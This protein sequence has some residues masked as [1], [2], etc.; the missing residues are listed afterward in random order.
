MVYALLTWTWDRTVVH[1]ENNPVHFIPSL[2][3]RLTSSLPLAKLPF[4]LRANAFEY[5][6]FSFFTIYPVLYM[7]LK[8]FADIKCLKARRT[9]ERGLVSFVYVV[10][11]LL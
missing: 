5:N 4:L 1:G 7:T 8:A 9:V 10:S 3:F 6:C 11:V 2:C